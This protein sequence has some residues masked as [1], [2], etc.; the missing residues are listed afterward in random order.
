L[1]SWRPSRTKDGFDGRLNAVLSQ[2]RV[3]RSGP[4][5]RRVFM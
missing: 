3:E 1:D 4:K 5:R 2:L